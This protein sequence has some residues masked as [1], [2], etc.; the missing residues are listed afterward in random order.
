MMSIINYQSRKHL[1]KK[2]LSDPSKDYLLV[3]SKPVF[4]QD[5]TKNYSDFSTDIIIAWLI[6]STFVLLSFQEKKRKMWKFFSKQTTMT[7]LPCLLCHV[8]SIS[9]F[10]FNFDFGKPF[11]RKVKNR[12]NQVFMCPHFRTKMK[13]MKTSSRT[14]KPTKNQKNQT[15]QKKKTNKQ[16]KKKQELKT[17]KKGLG[18]TTQLKL[19]IQ[20]T[21]KGNL[22]FWD[23]KKT[24]KANIKK[25]TFGTWTWTWNMISWKVLFEKTQ[26]PKTHKK[27]LENTTLNLKTTQDIKRE[28]DLWTKTLETWTFE[29]WTFELEH[30]KAKDFM[31][32]F[33]LG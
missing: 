31:N 17:H 6:L 8:A 24:K 9:M 5:E 25:V 7:H 27:V 21:S 23:N 20:R 3:F 28:L 16:L 1:F 13:K 19:R 4:Q 22:I 10:K 30:K 33:H 32:C 2:N 26:S 18:V 15:T 11:A 29:L 14:Q 12:F